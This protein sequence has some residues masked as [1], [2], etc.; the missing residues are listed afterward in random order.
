[1]WHIMWQLGI[2][3]DHFMEVKI[4]ATKLSTSRAHMNGR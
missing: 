1:M 3:K 4:I 2:K